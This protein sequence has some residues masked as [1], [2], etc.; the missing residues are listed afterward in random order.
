MKDSLTPKDL[1]TLIVMIGRSAIG[2]LLLKTFKGQ[3]ETIL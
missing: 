3:N 2:G 1:E